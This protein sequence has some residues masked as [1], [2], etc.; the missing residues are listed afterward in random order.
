MSA[1]TNTTT[2]IAKRRQ[3][4]ALTARLAE[5]RAQYDVLMN[6]FKFDE[7]RRL[8]TRIETAEREHRALAAE[9]PPQLDAATTPYRVARHRRRR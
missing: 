6:A 8:H 4:E 3:F 5:L 2:I 9:V 7:A 1:P